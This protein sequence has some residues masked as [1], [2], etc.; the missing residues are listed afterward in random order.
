MKNFIVLFKPIKVPNNF[1]SDKMHV[2]TVQ[3]DYLIQQMEV[4]QRTQ[5]DNYNID[6]KSI[7]FQTIGGKLCVAMI[8]FRK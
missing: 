2:D 6:E 4:S 3:M 1:D 8:A 7:S 5:M